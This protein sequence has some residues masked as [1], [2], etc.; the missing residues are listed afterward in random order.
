MFCSSNLRMLNTC[1]CS[2]IN[3]IL[4]SERKL[5]ANISYIGMPI[6]Q[7]ERSQL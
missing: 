5:L 2:N 1:L 3:C 4:N 6:K 7:K